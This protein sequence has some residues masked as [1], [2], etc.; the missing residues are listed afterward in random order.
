[1][2]FALA[3]LSNTRVSRAEDHLA[4]VRGIV[5]DYRRRRVAGVAVSSNGV[6]VRTDAAPSWSATPPNRTS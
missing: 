6:P 4:L 3:C 2:R 1:M 5:V